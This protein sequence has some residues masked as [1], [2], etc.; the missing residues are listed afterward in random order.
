MPG[1]VPRRFNG[2]YEPVWDRG[3]RHD[4]PGCPATY[5]YKSAFALV[6]PNWT[7]VERGSGS[8]SEVQLNGSH[9]D[10]EADDGVSRNGSPVVDTELA[11]AKPSRLDRDPRLTSNSATG[12]RRRR[13]LRH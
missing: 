10:E 3:L 6:G 7:G 4:A 12:P 1:G 13:P 5:L 8:E 11:D 9:L 2:G